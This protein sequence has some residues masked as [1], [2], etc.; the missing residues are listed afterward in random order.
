MKDAVRIAVDARDLAHDTRGIGR[1]TRAV[2]RQLL[3]RPDFEFTLLVYGPFTSRRRKALSAALGSE[4]FR[5]AASAR[6]CDALWHPA[7]G[8]FFKSRLPGTA[9]IHDAVPFRF[10]DP[11]PKRRAHQQQPFLRSV[12]TAAAFIAVSE[13]GKRELVDVFG[14]RPDRIR[15]IHHGVDASFSPGPAEV[16]ATLRERPYLL[17]V[18]E[19]GPAEPRKNFPLLY[20]AYRLAF[21]ELQAQIA[22]VGPSD[23]NLEGV[24]YAGLSAGDSSGSGD[25]FLRDLYRGALALCV[26]SYHETFGMPVVE[27]MACA[28]PVIVSEAACLPE[29]AG[30]AAAYAQPHDARSWAQALRD[31]VASTELRANLR[32]RGL[33]QA[34]KYDWSVSA[35]M[36]ADLFERVVRESKVRS[37]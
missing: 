16:P 9:T 12:R 4:R 7:N 30:D 14:L 36:H 6:G 25:T 31:V 18:G 27:A 35:S 11:D 37:S 19:T 28:T 5:V 1:Y 15:V 34:R 32:Q 23:P 33:A 2:L 21:P 17:F 26:P 10:P 13:F 22:V 29:I 8:T 20:E 3:A 24:Y